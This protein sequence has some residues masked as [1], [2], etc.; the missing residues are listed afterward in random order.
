MGLSPVPWRRMTIAEFARTRAQR[1]ARA[2]WRPRVALATCADSPGLIEDDEILARAFEYLDVPCEPAV[3]SDPHV[4]WASYDAVVVR[5]CG[6]SRAD[7]REFLRWTD[8]LESLRVP[9]FNPPRLIRWNINKQYL[10][11]LEKRGIPIAPPEAVESGRPA[12]AAELSLVFVD[13]TFT[14][15]V[16]NPHAPGRLHVDLR[17]TG[18]VQP[19]VIPWALVSATTYVIGTLADRPLFARID[20]F[21]RCNDFIMTELDVIDPELFLRFN[22][23][24]AL[25][26]VRALRERIVQAKRG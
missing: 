8:R 15:G 4:A 3:W 9:V 7:Q 5:S 25:T 14:H 2:P 21:M 20:G 12:G 23:A 17:H 1:Q 10:F 22:A 11:D 19:C 18:C 24:A 13:G 6:Q 26:L 16:A